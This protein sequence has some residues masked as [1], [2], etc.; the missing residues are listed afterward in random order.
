MFHYLCLRCKKTVHCTQLQH[1]WVG[2]DRTVFIS[3]TGDAS[4]V[5]LLFCAL[6]PLEDA[7]DLEFQQVKRTCYGSA[8]MGPMWLSGG[9]LVQLWLVVFAQLALCWILVVL[10]TLNHFWFIGVLCDLLLGPAQTIVEQNN[11][12]IWTQQ[13]HTRLWQPRASCSANIN[14][15]LRFYLTT[16]PQC[17][18]PWPTY[19]SKW[20]ILLAPGYP[21][22]SLSICSGLPLLRHKSVMSL[23]SWKPDG[24]W[25]M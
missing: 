9:C 7:G 18:S 1:V 12:T 22:C 24:L 2:T 25:E 21:W 14:R 20:T 10:L 16:P 8:E 17:R 4:T 19:R 6:S 23:S 11:L 5:H 13:R 3:G 15:P